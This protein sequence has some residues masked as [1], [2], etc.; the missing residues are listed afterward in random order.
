[1][2]LECQACSLTRKLRLGESRTPSKV[3]LLVGAGVRCRL[4]ESRGLQMRKWSSDSDAESFFFGPD[5]AALEA[6]SQ[7]SV[8]QGRRKRMRRRGRKWK[9][10]GSSFDIAVT[11]VWMAKSTQ[12]ASGAGLLYTGPGLPPCCPWLAPGLSASPQ[13][14]PTRGWFSCS[15]PRLLIRGCQALKARPGSASLGLPRTSWDGFK[16]RKAICSFCVEGRG[17]WEGVLQ[18]VGE[19]IRPRNCLATSQV[20]WKPFETM[21]WQGWRPLCAQRAACCCCASGAF[22]KWGVGTR[23]LTVL[24]IHQMD[25]PWATTLYLCPVAGCRKSTILSCYTFFSV[26]SCQLWVTDAV[27]SLWIKDLHSYQWINC[28]HSD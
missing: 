4:S 24:R 1:M 16:G 5:F 9:R 3:I 13:P 19:L 10:G 28:F 26:P 7:A 20:T 25:S 6:W 21:G 23:H 2:V 17:V 8:A 15:L 27:V 11:F 22:G 12:W 14:L 18:S